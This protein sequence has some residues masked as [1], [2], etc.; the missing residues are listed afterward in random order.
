MKPQSSATSSILNIDDAKAGPS[1]TPS[2]KNM[3]MRTQQLREGTAPPSPFGYDTVT[4]RESSE[5]Q[6]ITDE[7]EETCLMIEYC[8]GLRE[9]YLFEPTLSKVG[10]PVMGSV[11]IESKE[12]LAALKTDQKFKM[13]DGVVRVFSKDD[14]LLHEP[15]ASATAFFHDLHALM[16]IQSAGPAKSFCHKRLMLTEA[17]IFFARHVEFRCR[18]SRAKASATS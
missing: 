17:K 2:Y 1:T 6:T 10:S 9:K 13:V 16:I 3:R 5:G 4:L 14:E 12:A 8:I 15:P 18:V 11:E 7:C